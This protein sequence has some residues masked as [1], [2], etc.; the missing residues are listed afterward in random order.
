MFGF[1]YY[2]AMITVGGPLYAGMHRGGVY[3]HGLSRDNRSVRACDDRDGAVQRKGRAKA[4]AGGCLC[5]YAPPVCGGS[6]RLLIYIL[7]MPPSCDNACHRS[8]WGLPLPA[9]YGIMG[10]LVLL[11]VRGFFRYNRKQ[12]EKF[13]L[14]R[15]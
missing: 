4:A 11:T 14:T 6:H 13:S 8:V 2:L 9:F 15:P 5:R 7:R 12:Y 1:F 3:L 10:V